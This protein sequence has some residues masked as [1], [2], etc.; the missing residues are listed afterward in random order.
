MHTHRIHSWKSW[1]KAKYKVVANDVT[2]TAESFNEITDD[3][4]GGFDYDDAATVTYTPNS[5]IQFAPGKT[6]EIRKYEAVP[7]KKIW[8][9]DYYTDVAADNTAYSVSYYLTG[10]PPTTGQSV[11]A[12]PDIVIRLCPTVM[13]QVVPK[14]VLFSMG[15]GEYSDN[16]G[17]IYLG[18]SVVGSID[19]KT[20][21]VTLTSWDV[22]SSTIAVKSLLTQYGNWTNYEANFRTAGYPLRPASFYVSAFSILDGVNMYDTANQ[23]GVLATARLEGTIDVNTGT[24][25]IKYGVWD[26]KSGNEAEDWYDVLNLEYDSLGV[27][28]GRVWHPDYV[29]PATSIYNAVVFSSIPVNPDIVGINPARLPSDGRVPIFKKGGVAVIHETTNEAAPNGLVADQSFVVAGSDYDLIELY[30]QNVK[31]VGY[32]LYTVDLAT[33]TVTM[34]NPLDL[35]AYSEP[36]VAYKRKEDMLTISDVQINGQLS[37]A[38]QI[39]NAYTLAAYISSAMLFGDLASRYNTLFDQA[40]WSGIFSDVV[41]G[42]SA[43]GTYDE[44]T[45]PL[46]LVNSSAVEERWAIVF[47]NSTTFDLHSE[48]RGV[49]LTGQLISS[50]L[51]PINPIT[52]A[53]FFTMAAAGFGA[54]WST[55]NAIR[56]NTKAANAPIWI[57]RT[58]MPSDDALTPTDNFIVQIRGDAA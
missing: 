30:D 48:K 38:S 42:G 20:A 21:I 31:H 10:A 52:G 5:N 32:G 29:N 45:Y 33:S 57:N 24:A 2:Q 3:G 16:N 4:V 13:N 27:E 44:L 28:T 51:A 23:D 47:I 55:G 14:S 9:T 43:S 58:T 54:G 8:I 11:I 15:G 22:G 41:S 19:Y 36:L 39:S 49:I 25:Q 12:A 56:F 6:R 40:T 26:T 50:P 37:F 53:P 46:A 1:F 18:G 35:S 7:S 34:G 17:D